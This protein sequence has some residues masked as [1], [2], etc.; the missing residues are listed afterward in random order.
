MN[1]F[2][3]IAGQVRRRRAAQVADMAWDIWCPV[4][5]RQASLAAVWEQH[6]DVRPDLEAHIGGGD[7]LGNLVLIGPTGTGKTWTAAAILRLV[8]FEAAR[9]PV[10]ITASDLLA[11]LRPGGPA[12]LQHY[13]APQAEVLFLDD[14]GA[15]RPTE[16]SIEQLS[17]IIDHRWTN[18]NPTVVTS[19]L[20]PDALA[21]HLGA[22]AWSRLTGSDSLVL[23]LGGHD[24]R[25]D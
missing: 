5:A 13:L 1:D 22:R 21:E 3:A 2:D 15:E 7:L 11:T 23:R 10:F 9:L 4:R 17:S 25:K 12:Q 19:N 18:Q 20:E 6:P 16:W 14:V 24:R 8:I